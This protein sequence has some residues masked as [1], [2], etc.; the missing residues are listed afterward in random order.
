M[1]TTVVA[2]YSLDIFVCELIY[3]RVHNSLTVN[4]RIGLFKSAVIAVSIAVSQT[5]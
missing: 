3:F 4:I 1:C 5:K 2:E